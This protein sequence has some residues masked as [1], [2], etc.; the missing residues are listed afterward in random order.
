M[1]SSVGKSVRLRFFRVGANCCVE[2]GSFWAAYELADDFVSF[3][4]H[5][6]VDDEHRKSYWPE[7]KDFPSRW[8][9]NGQMGMIV[10]RHIRY[11]RF[12]ANSTQRTD[13]VWPYT[14]ERRR[15]FSGRF[16]G[17][18]KWASRRERCVCEMCTY[19]LATFFECPRFAF[20]LCRSVV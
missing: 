9:E 8:R 12:P 20:P 11:C 15:H 6:A 5:S 14:F 13:C 16:T 19:V 3:V 2:A 7:H 18:P 1:S 10:W 17:E 4:W